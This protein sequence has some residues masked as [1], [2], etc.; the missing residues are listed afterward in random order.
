MEKEG[1]KMMKK[2]ILC[3]GDSNT[4]GANLKGAGTVEQET[5]PA[6]LL[7]ELNK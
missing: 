2:R 7:R 4:Y 5:Y 1:A 6:A 3:Y